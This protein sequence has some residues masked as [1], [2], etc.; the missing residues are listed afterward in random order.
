[1]FVHKTSISVDKH[2][3]MTAFVHQNANSVDKASKAV[4]YCFA[5]FSRISVS[6]WMFFIL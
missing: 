4:R 3:Q 6:A 5:M 1:M 2:P